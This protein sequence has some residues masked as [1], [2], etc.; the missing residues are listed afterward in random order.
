MNWKSRA[1]KLTLHA[2]HAKKLILLLD[3][4][5][6]GKLMSWKIVFSVSTYAIALIGYFLLLTVDLPSSIMY[7]PTWAK[8][9]AFAE[10]FVE[11]KAGMGAFDSDANGTYAW[12]ILDIHENE[13]GERVATINETIKGG[14]THWDHVTGIPPD[15]RLANISVRE[16]AVRGLL[17]W[18]KRYYNRMLLSRSFFEGEGYRCQLAGERKTT[19]K[20]EPIE[21]IQIYPKLSSFRWADYDEATGL[22]LS[23]RITWPRIA[24]VFVS[25]NSTNISFSSSDE[26][27]LNDL[28][29][30]NDALLV[31][32]LF[33]LPITGAIVGLIIIK[34]KRINFSRTFW[35]KF[36]LLNG[37]ILTFLAD[38][39]ATMGSIYAPRVYNPILL[40]V[41][42]PG[43][44]NLAFWT[45]TLAVA[46]IIINRFAFPLVTKTSAAAVKDPTYNIEPASS[47]HP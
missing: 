6:M 23:Y 35:L 19:F 43:S 12:E 27:T 34:R 29:M 1:S 25:L 39:P 11:Y 3:E 9:G 4:L 30:I 40:I 16:G 13:G 22:L 33:I 20:G 7:E 14:S 42:I 10:Y 15:G 5:A 2:H 36:I 41:L 17:L 24:Y 32:P 26:N 44:I 28:T 21:I 47:H 18:V 46:V 8:E 38:W 31:S 37:M 45:A